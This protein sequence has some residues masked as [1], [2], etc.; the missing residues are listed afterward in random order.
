MEKGKGGGGGKRKRERIRSIRG[1]TNC[2]KKK[3][4]KTHIVIRLAQLPD[5]IPPDS[6]VLKVPP[7]E[8]KR[9]VH[10]RVGP[11]RE[12]VDGLADLCRIGP[13]DAF[14]K[15]CERLVFKGEV[16]VSHE[17]VHSGR[18]GEGKWDILACPW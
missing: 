11:A 18:N 16:R 13:D 10:V 2:D 3:K 9:V 6:A 4:K 14:E 15:F 7:E 5:R 12:Q 17:R 8:L 1:Y